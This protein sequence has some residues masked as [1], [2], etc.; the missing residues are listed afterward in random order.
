MN[1]LPYSVYKKLGLREL[2]PKRITLE[3][4]D[5][6]I[7]VPKGIIEDVLIQVYTVYYPLDFIILDT[8]PVESELSKH[9]IPV[10]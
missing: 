3:L 10:I 1:C 7:K 4:A 9:H 6:S 8:Q 5:W 2:K